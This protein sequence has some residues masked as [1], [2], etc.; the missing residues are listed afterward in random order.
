MVFSVCFG[1]FIFGRCVCVEHLY[2]IDRQLGSCFLS[3]PSCHISL[4]GTN[5]QRK[6]RRENS[7]RND[8]VTDSIGEWCAPDMDPLLVCRSRAQMSQCLVT[9]D[10]RVPEKEQTERE[11]ERERKGWKKKKKKK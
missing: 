4:C 7:H 5:T 3:W 6:K 11:R 8:W 9:T 10:R 2:F 1:D